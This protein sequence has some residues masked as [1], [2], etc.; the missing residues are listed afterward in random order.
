[1]SH[2]SPAIPNENI[3][4]HLKYH[5]IQILSPITHINAGF[6]IPE[7]ANIISYKRQVYINPDDFQKLPKSIMINHENT[8]HRIFLADDTIYIC[9]LKGHTSTQ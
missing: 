2:V 7:L 9:K 6:N 8:P 5:N 3:I 1:M 4:S